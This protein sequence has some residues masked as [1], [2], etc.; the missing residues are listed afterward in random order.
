MRKI[1][2][3]TP[4]IE[5]DDPARPG[6]A[7]PYAE[8]ILARVRSPAQGLSIEQIELALAVVAALRRARAGGLDHLLLEEPAWAYLRGRVNEGGWG[9]VDPLIPAF[10]RAVNE[11]PVVPVREAG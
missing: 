11:A 5:T 10:V 6:E 9:L 7:V 8:L 4:C 2:L 1:P 3:L